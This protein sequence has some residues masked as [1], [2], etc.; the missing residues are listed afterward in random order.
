[1]SQPLLSGIITQM[2]QLPI[3]EYRDLIEKTIEKHPVTIV[4]A[5][6]GAG[7]STRVPLWMWKKNKRVHVTQP[8][9]IAARS[10]PHYLARLIGVS[11]GK[12]IGYQT[13][14]DSKKSRD[15]QLLYVTDGVQM[16]REIKEKRDYDILFLDEVHEWNLNQEILIGIVKKNLDNGYYKKKGKHVVVMSATLEA[17]KLSSF[18][19]Q[20]PIIT[21]S[22]RGY[23]VAMHHNNPH[24]LLPD[25]AQMV[26]MEKNVLVFQPGKSEIEEFIES[27]KEML[28]AEKLKAKILPLHAELTVNE[29]ARVFEHYPI[30]KVIVATDIAQTSLTIDDID[31]VV[32]S[33]LKKEIR[34]VKGIEGLYPVDVSSAECIQRAGR[35]GR[36]KKG[37]YFLCADADIRDRLPFPEPEIRRLN[38][39][40][41]VL[42]LIKRGISPLDFPFF[43]S[44]DKGLIYKA[45][46]KLKIFGAISPEGKVTGEG[47]R[48]AEL[49]VSIRS[50]K[51]LLEAGKANPTVV[52]SAI[53]LISILETKGITNRSYTGEK[54]STGP[55]NS[56]L[57]N[58]LAIWNS[59]RLNRKIISFKKLALAKEVHR[60]LKKRL[61]V[62]EVKGILHVKDIRLLFRA[63]LSAFMDEVYTREGGEYQRENE[64]RQL[65]R[66]SI[67]FEPQ[68]EMIVGLP[69]DLVVTREN[70]ETGEKEEKPISLITFASEITFEILEDLKP[71][72]YQK[73]DEVKIQNGKIRVLREIYF[74]EKLIKSLHTPPNLLDMEE[75]ETI[76]P[77]V[78]KWYETNR[79]KYPICARREK[80]EKDFNEIRGIVKRK[81]KPF[82]HYWQE[83][84]SREIRTQLNMDDI[85]MFFQFHKGFAHI[86]LKKLL[87]YHFLKELKQSRWPSFIEAGGGILKILFI[88]KKS[89]VKFDYPQFEKVK[90]EET[91]LP[92]GERVGIILGQRKFFEW[93]QA[94]AEFNYWKRIDIFEKRQKKN[95]R[96]VNIEDLMEIPFPRV[97]EGGRG[98]DN[99]P[100]EYYVVP[101]IEEDNVF[102]KYFLTEDEAKVYFDSRRLEWEQYIQNYKKAK[103]ENIFKQKGWK[104]KS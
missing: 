78:L 102:L 46:K 14:F 9:R 26:E 68:P 10:L 86:T 101:E 57:L 25:A 3:D 37:Q 41:V 95:R 104:V 44:P 88:N 43:H 56:D 45:I 27:L 99:V 69:F 7:K 5:E 30:P 77:V 84:L 42:R 93:R 18:L 28:E 4:T 24:F 20:A 83:F 2:T 85:I 11:L 39:E 79:G 36:V 50:A 96:P 92:T 73:N 60:E 70:R 21:I 66:K 49:P 8:R 90:E 47:S 6:T 100:L 89:F 94:A 17:G 19:N 22:G 103:I 67:L 58:Q 15:T 74:G 87:P 12:E 72:S 82:E 35:A 52:D 98:K 34:L 16:I 23:P 32:D 54:Y 38:L 53:R 75:R 71:Y 81:L 65:D 64:E 51:L 97:L 48:M 40:S 61:E 33:G 76:I 91:I 29:Q 63:V 62:P 59:F 55:F 1:M 31:A 13:G 80:L